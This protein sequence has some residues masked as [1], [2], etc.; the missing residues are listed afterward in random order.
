ML[1]SGA[2]AVSN[3]TSTTGPMICATLPFTWAIE[4][5]NNDWQIIVFSAANIS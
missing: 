1:G 3:D 5:E 2:T 4:Y